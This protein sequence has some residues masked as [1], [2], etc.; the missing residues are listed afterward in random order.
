MAYINNQFKTL[1][2]ATSIHTSSSEIF[3]TDA[4]TWVTSAISD[5]TIV[6]DYNGITYDRGKWFF[7]GGKGWY[8]LNL[9]FIAGGGGDV[10]NADLG[11]RFVWGEAETYEDASAPLIWNNKGG[12]Y[13]SLNH[14]WIIY[15]NNSD[16][17]DSGSSL[18]T[19]WKN[20]DNDG[21]FTIKNATLNILRIS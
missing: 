9:N 20:L 16:N 21:N 5:Q 10:L 6:N 7:D 11:F 19:Q 13:W 3:I 2:W 12:N 8:V 14:S 4:D 1:Q 17:S 18:I 15:I